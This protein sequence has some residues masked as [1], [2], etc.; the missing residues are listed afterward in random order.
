VKTA[1]QLPLNVEQAQNDCVEVQLVREA[2]VLCTFRENIPSRWVKWGRLSESW[3]GFFSR[4]RSAMLKETGKV[5]EHWKVIGPE[6]YLA[7][8]PTASHI[9]KVPRPLPLNIRFFP[10]EGRVQ[11]A[12]S[13][14]PVAKGKIRVYVVDDSPT[15]RLAVRRILESD[16]SFELVGETGDPEE[17]LNQI[18]KVKPDVVSL[19]LIM[20]KM[21]GVEMMFR[22]KRHFAVPVVILSA[23]SKEEGSLVM[24]ALSLGAI[25]FIQKPSAGAITQASKTL[26]STLRVASQS[27]QGEHQTRVQTEAW[28]EDS[29]ILIGASTGGTR[30]IEVLL[31][32]FPEKIPPVLITQHIP[33]VFS[34]A[35]AKRLDSLLPF[36]VQEAEQG[37]L[38]LPNRVLVAPGGKQMKVVKGSDSKL[39][40]ELTSDP[41]VNGFAPSVDYLFNSASVLKARPR[42]VA[43]LLTGMGKDGAKGLLNLRADGVRTIAED[44]STCVVFGMPR[45]AIELKA[46]EFV[47]PLDKV[48]PRLTRLLRKA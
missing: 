38:L 3:E 4:T 7:D 16:P 33:A 32:A 18:P 12:R 28:Q 46:A 23:L 47:E 27:R 40:V 45:E 34:T 21:T 39:R 25:D 1:E 22:L 2:F 24:E 31:K 19:D 43:I 9:S 20:P 44:E 48:A 11:V 29:L 8:V 26:C 35:F 13:V 36:Q 10:K 6:E 42:S 41:P 17:A 5:P 15:V 30:A 14:V 37:D